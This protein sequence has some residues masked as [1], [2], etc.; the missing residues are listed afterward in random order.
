MRTRTLRF[1]APWIAI[2]CLLLAVPVRAQDDADPDALVRNRLHLASQ[3]VREQRIEEAL[4]LYRQVYETHPDHPKA[5]RGLK[6][7]LLELKQYDELLRVIR[8]ELEVTPDHPALLEEL[9]T[10]LAQAGDRAAATEAWR[11]ILRV[12]QGSRGAYSMV[13]D[14]MIR[15]RLLDEALDVYAEADSLFPSSFTRQKAA[16]HELRFEFDRATAEYLSYLDTSPTALSYVEGRL[17]RIGEAEDG[18]L[19]VIRRVAAWSETPAPAGMGA[20]RAIVSRKLL[21]D[22]YLEA[23]D[24]EN[25]RKEYFRLVDEAPQQAASLLV[26]GKRCQSDGKFETAIRVFERIVDEVS[27]ARAVPSA[28]TEIATSQR[29]LRR[30]EDAIATYQRL[31]DDWP[32]TD[33]ALAARYEMARTLRDGLGRAS[34]AEEV[35]RALIARGQGPWAEA[36]PQFEVAE[37]AVWEG[38]LERARGIYAAIGAR[39][40]SEPTHE[41][42]LFEEGRANF[43]A[44]DFGVADSLF[45]QVAQRFP[46]GEHVNDALEFSILLNTNPDD[47]A[48]L[49]E[50]AG[51][52][53][54]LRTNRPGEA[55]R[56]LEA[57]LAAHPGAAITDESW[58]LAG[59]AHRAAG[60]PQ[61][62]LTALERA[63]AEAQ[64]PDLAADARLLRATIFAED[65]HDRAT[66]LAECEELLVAFPET[67]AA[68]RARERAAE[69]TRMI[70]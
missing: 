48:V 20:G 37:C 23:G 1:A 25:A 19:P 21:G 41:R 43:Y 6:N 28:L 54:A 56:R 36:D 4:D 13:A 45:K 12:Q 38:D 47:P 55:N 35:F 69:L 27:D 24:H 58:L 67:L 65:L 30:Y 51:A 68:D 29:E 10:V 59:E 60:E 7:C 39:E 70:P 33:F 11:K 3:Y 40:F 17:L 52:Q 9:G 64:V 46:R 50:Y 62:A 61:R 14:L 22:L 53:L 49:G 42:A 2:A 31:I 16:L 34:E 57:L 18:L 66:A 15:N 5:L 32:E 8:R 44:G 63:V 26:F